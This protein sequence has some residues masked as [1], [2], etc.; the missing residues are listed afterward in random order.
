MRTL[1][2]HEA[3]SRATAHSSDKRSQI[4]ATFSLAALIL[5]LSRAWLY[6]HD[7]QT[8][9]ILENPGYRYFDVLVEITILA[10]TLALLRFPRLNPLIILWLIFA[11]WGAASLLWTEHAKY[12]LG[13]I[14]SMSV[15][16]VCSI[17]IR[18]HLNQRTILLT[19]GTTLGLVALGSL[20][21]SLLSPYGLATGAHYGFWRGLFQ[22]KNALGEFSAFSSL[23]LIALTLSGPMRLAAAPFAAISLT[24][25][26]MS[27]SINA[28]ATFAAGLSCFICL[29]YYHR[30]PGKG[31]V[32]AIIAA[33]LVI[34]AAVLLNQLWPLILFSSGRDLTFTGRTAIWA[35][36]LRYAQD[37]QLIGI[38]WGSL[39]AEQGI[40]NAIAEATRVPTLRTPH[41]AYITSYVETGAIG[42]ILYVIFLAG[43]FAYAAPLAAQQRNSSYALCA[44]AILGAALFGIFESNI[45]VVPSLWVPFA[46]LTSPFSA[47][48]RATGRRPHRNEIS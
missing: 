12:T 47:K 22:H 37:S 45:G 39:N 11:A 6:P 24:C 33:L 31:I 25:L 38:G 42:L 3:P 40:A 17:V 2:N 13:I 20:M 10:C 19:A 18:Q 44:A 35:H 7:A 21:L 34:F 43:A 4:L 36:F 28:A 1:K 32:R 8:S 26:F 27:G 9:L 41:S 23:I 16:T 46:I 30:V 29:R 5:W 48:T 14:R 15:L